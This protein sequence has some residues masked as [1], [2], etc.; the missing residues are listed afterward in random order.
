MNNTHVMHGRRGFADPARRIPVRM[1][2]LTP[3]SV[4]RWWREPAAL[5]RVPPV[6]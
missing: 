5:D 2:Y 6:R 4:G 3:E 1:G